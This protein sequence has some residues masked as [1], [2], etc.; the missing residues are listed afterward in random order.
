MCLCAYPTQLVDSH[1]V[2]STAVLAP[3]CWEPLPVPSLW[4]ITSPLLG[5][6][7]GNSTAHAAAPWHRSPVPKEGKPMSPCSS[8]RHDRGVLLIYSFHAASFRVHHAGQLEELIRSIQSDQPVLPKQWDCAITAST[9]LSILWC[10][11]SLCSLC[12]SSLVE[13]EQK[14]GMHTRRYSPPQRGNAQTAP[15]WLGRCLSLRRALAGCPGLCSCS[16]S[17]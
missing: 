15:S 1:Q 12:L 6:E 10:G 16:E 4:G 8:G 9:S 13:P 3:I 2:Y 17:R 14:G 7:T 11:S 5:R